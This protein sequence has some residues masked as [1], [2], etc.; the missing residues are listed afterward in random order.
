MVDAFVDSCVSLKECLEMLGDAE[1]E[2]FKLRNDNGLQSQCLHQ[3]PSFPSG[4]DGQAEKEKLIIKCGYWR[5][6]LTR[7]GK[8]DDVHA[9]L[10]D[11]ADGPRIWIGSAHGA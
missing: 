8:L 5:S 3:D 11:H 10:L 9:G 1:P 6:C 2:S 7:N 4:V